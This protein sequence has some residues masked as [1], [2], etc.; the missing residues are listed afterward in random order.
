MVYLETIEKA[1]EVLKN[2]MNITPL[3]KNIHLSEKYQADI[4]LKREDLNTVRSYK[5]RG[6]YN[7]IYQLSDTEKKMGIVCASAGNHAQGVAYSCYHLNIYGKIYMPI[8]TTKQKIEQVKSFGK[9][10]VEVILTGDTFDDANTEAVKEAKQKGYSF[11]PPFEDEKI[12]E[13]QGT[14]ACEIL[15]QIDNKLIDYVVIPIGGGGLVAGMGLYFDRKSPSTKIIGVEPLGAP[16]MQKSLEANMLITLQNIDKFVDGAAVKKVGA[17]NFEI[18]KKFLTHQDIVL[19]PEGKVCTTLLQLYNESGIIVE[20][21]G[22]LSVSALDFMKET[23]K[24]KTVVVIISGG[25]N[26]I[27]RMPEIQQRSMLYEGLIHYFIIY[28]SQRAGALKEFLVNVLGPNDD[29][30]RFEYTKKTNRENG[31]AII[32][33]Q[34]KNKNDYQHLIEKMRNNHIVFEDLE[35]KMELFDALV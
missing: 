5:I 7:K 18:C 32:G 4:Y 24:G 17:I 25:N 1:R 27:L 19:I 26:D 22:A 3:Q 20:P 33:I 23:I 10:F 16:S 30:I 34:I 31:P 13:G 6:A 28:F 8:P 9:Q 21:A 2:V 12:I 11:I 35:D 14:V 29:I 15:E